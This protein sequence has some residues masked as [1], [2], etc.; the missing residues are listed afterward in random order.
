MSKAKQSALVAAMDKR[1]A[2]MTKKL[3]NKKY[4]PGTHKQTKGREHLIK[5]LGE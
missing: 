5:K 4:L 2:T 1:I 3:P